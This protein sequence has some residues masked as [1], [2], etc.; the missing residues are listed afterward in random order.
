MLGGQ[1]EVILKPKESSVMQ[2]KARR[3]AFT[4]IE[5]L[6]VSGVISV[7][8]A[9]LLPAVQSA[10]EAAR[11]AQCVNNLKQLGLALHNYEGMHQAFPSGYISNFTATGDD[12]GPGWGWSPMLLGQ[13]DQAPLLNSINFNRA[14]EDPANQTS[15]LVTVG[16]FLCPS[17][18][19]QV[20]WAVNRDAATGLPLM[21]IAQVAPA[22]YVAMYG[23]GEPGPDGDGLFFRNSRVAL[24]DITDGTSQ[25]IALGE[26]SHLLGEATWTGSVT[27]AI[28]YPTNPLTTVAR[29]RTE[30]SSGMVLG[31][32]GEGKGPGAPQSDVN[33]F[34]SL[35]TGGGV[36]F[37]FADGHVQFLK[38]TMNYQTYQAL[39]TR[40]GGEVVPGNY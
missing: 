9:L 38:A 6:V 15:R 11:R 16:S 40:A 36:N 5:L 10:R 32:V 34:Y 20:Y 28:L 33:T 31:H 18:Q 21:N 24:R 17:D 3:R 12:T 27:G 30:T 26:R 29:F 35:H 7:L 22:N 1:A 23:V 13:F 4:L 37:V 25:A 14:V 39:A 2:P 8:I 19:V